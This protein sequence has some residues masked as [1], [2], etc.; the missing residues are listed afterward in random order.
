MQD[1]CFFKED[2]SRLT[3]EHVNKEEAKVCLTDSVMKE[4][5]GD[6]VW[7]Y[8]WNSKGVAEDPW[9]ADQILDDL[10]TIGMAKNRVIVKTDQE[11][12]IVELQAEIARRRADIGTSLENSKV[13]DS[14]RNGKVE[15]AIRDVKNMV[16]TLKSALPEKSGL[17]L[18]LD[19]NIV[20]WMVRHASEAAERRHYR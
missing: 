1:Y 4:T 3:D 13:G 2:A 8:A 11:A 9:I 12:A 18:T 16:R 17:T 15:R 10:N 7:A 14:N 5:M 6:S 20:T 19:M